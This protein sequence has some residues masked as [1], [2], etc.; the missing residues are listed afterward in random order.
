MIAA[1]ILAAGESRRMGALKP[2]LPFGRSTMIE[3]IIASH[4]SAGLQRLVIVLGHEQARIA[5]VV[6][7][8]GVEIVVNELYFRGMASSASA[9]VQHLAQSRPPEGVLFSLVD[10]P[11]ILPAVLRLVAETFERHRDR[12]VLPAVRGRRGHPILFPW[13]IAVEILSLRGETS[14]KTIRDA[15][16]NEILE[17]SVEDDAILRDLDRPEDYQSEL[18]RRPKP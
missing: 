4:R 2:L 7:P 8:L 6:R 16:S 1:V 3:T 15:H 5:A 10:Q 17:V 14:L 9:A 13:R 12:I 18:Q 11:S